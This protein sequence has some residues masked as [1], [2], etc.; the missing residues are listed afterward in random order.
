MALESV[1]ADR[2]EAR[3][4]YVE[5]PAGTQADLLTHAGKEAVLDRRG[6]CR[7]LW[8]APEVERE[9]LSRWPPEWKRYKDTA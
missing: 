4:R 1:R 2:F 6:H 9:R 3:V 8:K 7:L 5:R